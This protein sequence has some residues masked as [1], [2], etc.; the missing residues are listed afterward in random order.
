MVVKTGV[1]IEIKGVKEAIGSIRGFSADKLKK[2]DQGV[3]RAGFYV[4]SEVQE[5]IAGHRAEPTSVDTGRF[6]QSPKTVSPQ[7]LIASVETNVEYSPHLEYGT[8]KMAPRSHFRNTA[9]R[10][11]P[12]VVDIIREAVK[13]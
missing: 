5:S 6:L 4:Q 2:A 8:S 1:T 12:K 13:S 10:S 3:K 11:R 7:P 9:D